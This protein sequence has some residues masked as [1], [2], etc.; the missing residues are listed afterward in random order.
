MSQTTKR[1]QPQRPEERRLLKVLEIE[2]RLREQQPVKTLRSVAYFGLP[3][4]LLQHGFFFERAKRPRDVR[5]GKAKQ[6][7]ANAAELALHYAHL[8]RFI[9]CEGFGWHPDSLWFTEHA[10]VFDRRTGKAID[11]TWSEDKANGSER[12][13]LYGIPFDPWALQDLL[14]RQGHYGLFV[15]HQTMRDVFFGKLNPHCFLHDLFK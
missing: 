1:T 7:F 12:T 6:C 5:K 8:D 3:D 9:Y 4:L 11:N 13:V 14:A 2:T 15:N 10:W